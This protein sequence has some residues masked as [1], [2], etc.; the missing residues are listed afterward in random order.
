M[1]IETLV[2]GELEIER[3]KL[4]ATVAADVAAECQMLLEGVPDP[5]YYYVGTPYTEE[6]EGIIKQSFYYLKDL[7]SSGFV[8]LQSVLDLHPH[9]DTRNPNV[10]INMQEPGAEQN[11]HADIVFGKQVIFQASDDGLFDY[12]PDHLNNDH[13]ETVEVNAGDVLWLN[14]PSIRHRGRNP[15][16]SV[17]QTLVMSSNVPI[18]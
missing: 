2:P 11:E 15:S 8:A 3:G 14:C 10:F 5:L 18:E 4:S 16:S 7:R 1:S 13:V 17:R 12:W 6:S 9:P